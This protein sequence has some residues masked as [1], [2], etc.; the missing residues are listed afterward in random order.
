MPRIG[1]ALPPEI[2][3]GKERLA[4]ERLEDACK[5]LEEELEEV[6]VKYDM[7]FL[8]VERME[9]ARRREEL[10]RAIARLQ[11]AF[12]RN[13]G[14]RFRVQTLHARFLSYERL[15]V[16]SAREKE[17]GTYRRDIIR[18]RRKAAGRGPAGPGKGAA[19][20]RRGA[21]ESEDVDLDDL[22]EEAERAAPP[23]PSPPPVA[24]PAPSTAAAQPAAAAPASP[25][26]AKPAEASPPPSLPGLGEAQMRA[27]YEAY[28]AAKKRCNEDTSRVT[29]EAVARSVNKQIPEIARVYK[30]RE[31]EFKVVIK[32]GK[33]I[34]KA[35]P[36]P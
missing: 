27:L 16:R 23:P 36:K 7:Y 10:K 11:N 32:D 21:L 20:G 12:T 17:E 3:T 14:L 35:V 26:P 30:A 15:W 22:T 13:A 9:P 25:A 2:E 33:A 19:R 18:A 34:L 8:G 31:V 28:V 5:E 6:K 29:Y 4:N 1:G 24:R